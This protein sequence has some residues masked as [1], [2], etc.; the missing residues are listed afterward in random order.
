MYYSRGPKGRKGRS[1]E[2]RDS[3]LKRAR[4][5]VPTAL[6]SPLPYTINW[7]RAREQRGVR[8]VKTIYEKPS[9]AILPAARARPSDYRNWRLI[10]AAYD[11]D[12]VVKKKKKGKKGKRVG[13][14]VPFPPR[15]GLLKRA[16]RL[17]LRC[18]INNTAPVWRDNLTLRV[19]PSG[20]TTVD[21]WI[22]PTERKFFAF[23][24]GDR[25]E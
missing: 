2:A 10:I 3:I 15:L 13:K 7:A 19:P 21:Q 9:Y 22:L 6:P 24:E 17:F 4:E 12:T 23:R 11:Y 20:T 1:Q 8:L 25:H 5:P 18:L 16:D 14:L